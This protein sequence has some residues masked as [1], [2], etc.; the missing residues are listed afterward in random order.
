[1][2]K[3]DLDAIRKLSVAERLALVEEIWDSISDD[4]DSA[5]VTKRQLAEAHRRLAEHDADPSTVIPW[6]QAEA[7]LRKKS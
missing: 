4:P 2:V 7:N 1:M 5:P 3:I 6:D